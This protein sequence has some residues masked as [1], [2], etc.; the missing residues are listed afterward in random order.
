MEGHECLYNLQYKHYDNNLVNDNFR[1]EIEGEWH[2]GSKVAADERHGMCES[3]FNTAWERHGMCESTLNRTEWLV[4]DHVPFTWK[5]D[6]RCVCH[7]AAV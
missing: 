6:L 7:A 1:K 2:G 3:A 5:H 4:R